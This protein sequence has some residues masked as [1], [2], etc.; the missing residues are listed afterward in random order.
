MP[1]L[2]DVVAYVDLWYVRSQAAIRSDPPD[3]IAVWTRMLPA[4]KDEGDRSHFAELWLPQE[5]LWVDL[6]CADYVSTEHGTTHRDFGFKVRGVHPGVEPEGGSDWQTVWIPRTAIPVAKAGGPG[7]PPVAGAVTD[8][9]LREALAA[10]LSLREPT[11]DRGRS[12]EFFVGPTSPVAN[13][14]WVFWN[15]GG[16]VLHFA[17][18]GDL[19]NPKT[20]AHAVESMRFHAVEPGRETQAGRQAFLQHVAQVCRD[21]GRRL[22]VDP[23]TAGR[24]R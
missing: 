23:E 21:Q 5:K 14:I 2:A 24:G 7:H 18:D 13:E 4:G 17:A 16:E 9:R 8:A 15:D 20:W 1:F 12:Q 6:K 11:D 3:A 22:T 19:E 10:F